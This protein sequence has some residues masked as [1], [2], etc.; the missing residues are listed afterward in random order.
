MNKKASNGRL[1]IIPLL[2]ITFIVLYFVIIVVLGYLNSWNWVG[3]VEYSFD[4]NQP[5]QI[6][7]TK[8]LWDWMELLLVPLALAV[9]GIW[10]THVQKEADLQIALEK[11]R[12]NILDNYF[13]KMT[14][15][16]LEKNLWTGKDPHVKNLAKAR[17]LTVLRNLDNQR[18]QQVIQ[19]LQ[20]TD[21]VGKNSIIDFSNSNLDGVQLQN[22]NLR[23][24]NFEYSS[25][26]RANFS[27]A[28]MIYANLQFSD[29]KEANFQNAIMSKANLQFTNLENASLKCHL[30][31]AKLQSANL[32]GSD[33]SDAV[34]ENAEY[35]YNTKWPNGFNI[36]TNKVV[37][38]ELSEDET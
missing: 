3:V 19:F 29:L 5:N 25:L 34:L 37:H 32:Q 10:F 24:I 1:K 36:E 6:E 7:G 33:L 21:L 18:N 35:D 20:E 2:I 14:E 27:D 4:N 28:N 31:A 11:Q 15:L 13:D 23:N 9:A 22:A 8:S 30:F 12:Q 38:V 17:T 26:I 16:I